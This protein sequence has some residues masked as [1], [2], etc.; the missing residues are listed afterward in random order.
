MESGLGLRGSHK[1]VP[2]LTSPD[3]DL[4]LRL[5][6]VLHVVSDEPVEQVADQGLEHH[7]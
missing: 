7:D 4:Q 3:S 5:V 1:L 6:Q 2:E